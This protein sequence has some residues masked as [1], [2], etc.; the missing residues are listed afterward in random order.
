VFLTPSEALLKAFTPSAKVERRSIFLTEPQAAAIEK[1]AGAKLDSKI[2]TYYTGRDAHGVVGTALF[3]T[4][5][6]RTMPVTYM[7]LLQPS[8]EIRY[9]EVLA[10]HEP[11]DYLPR[12]EWLDLYKGKRQED[13]LR[14]RRDIPNVAGASL[15][16][17]TLNSGIR[18]LLAVYR[19][20][21]A[22]EAAR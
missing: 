11:D 14:L 22:A 1:A 2:F 4:A 9:V 20:V 3:D 7:V 10:F 18:K 13:S 8:G 15:T 16:A 12:S 19:T 5:I 21:I 6:V 17:Q